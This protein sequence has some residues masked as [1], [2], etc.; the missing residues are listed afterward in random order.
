MRTISILPAV[1]LALALAGG[2]A[3]QPVSGAEPVPKRKLL[4]VAFDGTRPDALL[5]ANSVNL[6][7]LLDGA[8]YSF[9]ALAAG[10]EEDEPVSGCG[11]SSMFTG[12]W[13]ADHGV[14]ANDFSASR[15]DLHPIFFCRLPEGS[16]VESIVRWQPLQPNL[17]KCAAVNDAPASDAAAADEAVRLLHD[18][19]PQVLFVH[20]EDIDTAGH[21]DGFSADSPGYLAAIEATDARLGLVLAALRARPTFS[22]EDWLVVC[23]ADHGGSGKDHH[24]RTLENRTTF[25]VVAGAHAA[26]GEIVPPPVLVDLAPT[27]L[28]HLGVPIDPA[29]GFVGTAVGLREDPPPARRLPGDWTGDGLL[30]LADPVRLLGVLFLG[31]PLPAPCGEAASAEADPLLDPNGDGAIDLS[32][33]VHLLLHL[34]AGGPPPAE[35]PGCAP[36]PGCADACSG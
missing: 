19:D 20:F 5:K 18:T 35:G 28:T 17:I 9:Q 4:I 23:L 22:T 2:S 26:P 25:M 11:Y 36:S 27:A 30:D 1:A 33:A 34:F 12:V 14:C 21:R 7:G 31:D 8:A 32:D 29:W 15:F 10:G 3:D 13:C 16:V 24:A 6:K